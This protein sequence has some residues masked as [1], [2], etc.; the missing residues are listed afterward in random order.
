M[1]F[2]SDSNETHRTDVVRAAL[3]EAA[4][5]EPEAPTPDDLVVRA[6]ARQE[7]SGG[8][9]GRSRLVPAL[10]FSACGLVLLAGLALRSRKPHQPVTAESAEAYAADTGKKRLVAQA[11]PYRHTA[12]VQ[13][14]VA[15]E[16]DVVR[17]LLPPLNVE[18]F[19][20]PAGHASARHRVA[21]HRMCQ[22]QRRL[23]AGNTRAAPRIHHTNSLWTTE[24]VQRVVVTETVT[25]IWI[26]KTDPVTA[27]VVVTPALFQ[28]SL[29]P[30]DAADTGTSQVAATIIPVSFE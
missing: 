3:C 24:I 11:T 12:T 2:P 30:D 10:A 17:S 25:P 29:Q 15:W 23:W 21:H 28:L 26:A 16:Q 1:K 20:L 5:Y 9:C 18:R 27:T 22:P 14:P 13:N 7:R 19:V 8:R 4:R 6:L